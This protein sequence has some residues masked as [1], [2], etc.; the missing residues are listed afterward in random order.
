MGSFSNSTSQ[1]AYLVGFYKAI[2]SIG[3]VAAFKI[4]SALVPYM[5]TV[6][7]CWSLS[8]LGLICLIPV[9]VWKVTDRELLS[10]S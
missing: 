1:L 7:I 9:V 3:A 5:T 10:L 2:Q 8:V 6:I 4:D